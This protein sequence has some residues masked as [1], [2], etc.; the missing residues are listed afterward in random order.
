MAIQRAWLLVLAS[1]PCACSQGFLAANPKIRIA[2]IHEELRDAMADVL[3]RGHGISADRMARIRGALTPLFYSLPQNREGHLSTGVMRYVVQRYFR[4]QHG[5]MMKGFE[6]HAPSGNASGWVDSAQILQHNVPD[7]VRSVLEEKLSHDGFALEDSIVMIATLE[8]LILDE[9]VLGV[10]RAFYL[11]EFDSTMPLSPKE[12]TSVLS[13]YFINEML[14]VSTSNITLHQTKKANIRKTYPHWDEAEQ[15]LADVFWNDFYEHRQTLNPFSE[16]A[17]HFDDVVRISQ[18][19]A[20]EFGPFSNHE[21]DVMKDALASMDMQETGRVKIS[22]FYKHAKG[23]AWQFEEAFEYLRHSG[24]IDQSSEV[25]GAQVIIPNYIAGV[26]NCITSKHFYSICC[27]NECDSVYQHLEAEIPSAYAS[28]AEIAAVVEG[29]VIPSR[30]GR[31]LSTMLRTRLEDI[32]AHHDGKV[33]LHGR[34]IA[35]WLHFVFPRDCPYPHMVGTTN[36]QSPGLFE[37]VHGAGSSDATEA[38][39]E[40]FI[41]AESAGITPSPEAGLL[42]WDFQEVLLDTATPSD[43]EARGTSRS[44]LRI[45]ALLGMLGSMVTLGLKESK[46]IFDAVRPE[47]KRVEH[48]V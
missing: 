21:C 12:F 46:R 30:D 43:A 48:A 15:F 4:E 11:N 32:A 35:Q 7:F 37:K 16:K 13:S 23:G 25:L 45:F 1:L 47:V 44:V 2:S 19:V 28:A 3:G 17:I 18:R 24:A 40:Q 41:K 8:R 10:R 39:M 6:P 26:N 34:L 14:Q 36:P 31:N 5:W 38:E 33:P 20:E 9:V 27:L 22:D 29:V 42:M